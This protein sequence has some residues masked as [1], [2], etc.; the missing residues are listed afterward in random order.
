MGI[1]KAV[2]RPGNRF[3]RVNY[4]DSVTVKYSGHVF[5]IQRPQHG[6]RG[7][8]FQSR[9]DPEFTTFVKENLVVEG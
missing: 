8:Q 5:D 4:G 9:S 2:L 3:N 1:K 7:K 6:F